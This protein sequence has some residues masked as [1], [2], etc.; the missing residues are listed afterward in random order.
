[1]D[2]VIPLPPLY[3]T[4]GM[5]RSD[6]YLYLLQNKL[7]STLQ[8]LQQVILLLIIIFNLASSCL[9]RY[10]CSKK[11]RPTL[12]RPTHNPLT[13]QSTRTWDLTLNSTTTGSDFRLPPWCK[14]RLGTSGSWAALIGWTAWPLKMRP[15]GCPETSVTN[16]QPT[17][18]CPETSVTNYQPTMS[19]ISD[20]RRPRSILYLYYLRTQ[21]IIVSCIKFNITT[22]R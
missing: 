9:Y 5:L 22:T 16:Y 21:P 7:Q 14:W 15:I 1:M 10:L 18:G 17:I 4:T 3:A 19:N 6:L 11:L 2:K 20:G 13:Q 8:I 12:Q